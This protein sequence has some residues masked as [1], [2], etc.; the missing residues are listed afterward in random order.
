MCHIP[1]VFRHTARIF[2]TFTPLCKNFS[3][4]MHDFFFQFGYAG[5]HLASSMPDEG[6][7]MNTTTEKS[8]RTCARC[9]VPT[10]EQTP[11]CSA[12]YARH[13]ARAQHQQLGKQPGADPGKPICPRC[14]RTAGHNLPAC[15]IT[16]DS[17]A[18]PVEII[19]QWNPI[20]SLCTVCVSVRE[21]TV[22]LDSPRVYLPVNPTSRRSSRMR[23]YPTR[24][25]PILFAGAACSECGAS[26]DSAAR[27]AGKP[28]CARHYRRWRKH[29]LDA[30]RRQ[31]NRSQV[32][33]AYLPASLDTN[34][35]TAQTERASLGPADPGLAAFLAARRARKAGT[36]KTRVRL[37]PVG[38]QVRGVSPVQPQKA[39][40]RR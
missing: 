39:A 13:R 11:G 38:A 15:S 6:K 26:I 35:A 17:Y 2:E 31:R 5:H 36:T 29:R 3:I 24:A 25:N 16:A 9:G 8:Q 40:A 27:Q 10:H 1:W 18:E 23:I 7:R 28:L 21:G 30:D 14:W 22:P 4:I 33:P 34:K 19:N 32:L 20:F 12:C 37:G